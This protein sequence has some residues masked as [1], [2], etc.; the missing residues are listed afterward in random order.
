MRYLQ[1][2]PWAIVYIDSTL[3]YWHEKGKRWK[4]KTPQTYTPQSC[5]DWCYLAAVSAQVRLPVSPE[6][7]PFWWE[8]AKKG[9]VQCQAR[10]WA[11]ER[12]YVFI[13]HLAFWYPLWWVSGDQVRLWILG[14]QIEFLF[15]H[16]VSPP[17]AICECTFPHQT[18]EF[19]LSRRC[20]CSTLTTWA[21]EPVRTRPR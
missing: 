14:L 4:H 21:S 1:T 15:V 3:G 18:E 12:E 6:I 11:S 19:C 10:R 17:L 5:K 13:F 9:A 8:R 16:G 7:A 20:V 2:L